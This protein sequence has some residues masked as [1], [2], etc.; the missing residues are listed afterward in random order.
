MNRSAP[1]RPIDYAE[2]ALITAILEGEYPPGSVL[3]G[4]RDL[5]A[6]LGVTR[7][8]LR[9]ALQRLA[10]DGWLLI[11]QGK[12]TVVNDFWWNG[13]L[14]VIDGIVRHSRRLPDDF[15]A[16]LLRVRLDLA[17]GYTRAAVASA[18][19]RVVDLLAGA[20]ALEDEAQAYAAFDW[21]LHRGLTLAS[22]NPV[23]A[24]ILNG[25]AGLYE[26][27]GVSYFATE[28]ARRISREFYAAL[29]DAA[30][31][32]DADA[33]ETIAREVMGESIRVWQAIDGK[34]AR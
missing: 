12:P 34:G 22:G 29:S 2:E 3:P 10:R 9:E 8:T 16:N 24:L 13:G 17:P 14:N 6:M 27:M 19:G 20:K 21:R 23:Y 28:A 4:E 25:F 31:R 11:H 5:A 18:A 26:A 33:A 30:R 7:P 32:G 15:V 1:Q